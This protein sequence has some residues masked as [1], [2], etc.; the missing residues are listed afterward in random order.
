MPRY[1]SLFQPCITV[2]DDGTITVDWSDSYVNTIEIDD[3][4]L[5]GDVLYTS[6]EGDKHSKFLDALVID[7]V[8]T[9]QG[10]RRLA[11]HIE[12]KENQ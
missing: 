10:L 9:T 7:G 12:S 4:G 11:D 8:S 5:P 6:D 2:E 3:D 1:E